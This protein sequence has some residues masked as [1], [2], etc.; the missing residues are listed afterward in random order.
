MR[1]AVYIIFL[2]VVTLSAFAAERVSLAQLEAD[3]SQYM[4]RDV[5]VTDPLVVCGSFYDS[6]VLAPQR[7]FCADERA[8]RVTS[9][10]VHCR[11]KY[12]DVRTGDIV[13]GLTARVTGERQLLTGKTIRTHH[14]PAD[15]LARPKKGELRI[16]GA[17]IEN[18]F[19]DLGGYAHRKTTPAQQALQ[20]RKLVQ[21]LRAMHADLF[22]FCEMQVGNKAPEMLLAELNKHG[23]YAYVSMPMD[24]IDR[25]GCCFVYDTRRVRPCEYPI[26]AYHDSTSHYYA[27]MFAQ[28]F[29]DISTGEKLIISLNHLKSKRPGREQYDTNAKRMEN[30]DSLLVMLPKAITLYGDSDLLLLGDYNCYTLEQPIRT[31]VQAGYADMLPLGGEN[32]YSYVYKGEAGY[33]D[34]CFA[35]PSMSRQ[36]VRVRPWHV[37]A[38]WYYQ[39][40]AY[41]MKD[42]SM[43]RY[44][45]HD[46]IVVD[47]RLR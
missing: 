19:A 8:E 7:L 18:Y 12:Y 13:R 15:R 20:T 27:R 1:K 39:H 2:L 25:I 26:S 31:I 43:H 30:T 46:P 24:N 35:N 32:D 42:K 40:G 38:D 4:N 5:C 21:A 41:K 28:G 47:V 36:I 6:L 22:A 45:D 10:C 17:N 44:S 3:W 14:Q 33:L 34:R 11:N 23:Q 29:E 16:V 37:N 9:V